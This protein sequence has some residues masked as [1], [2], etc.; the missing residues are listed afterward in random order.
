L[1]GGAFSAPRLHRR[2]YRQVSGKRRKHD[3]A[4]ARAV[5]LGGGLGGIGAGGMIPAM[6]WIM[7][8]AEK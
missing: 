6:S 1:P 8:A 4:F 3:I 7:E 2:D 5:R